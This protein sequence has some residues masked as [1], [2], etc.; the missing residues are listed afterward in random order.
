MYKSANKSS[1]ELTFRE[2]STISKRKI[3]FHFSVTLTV[4]GPFEQNIKKPASDSGTG[5]AIR[6]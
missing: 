4:F 3:A 5:Q 2:Q 6:S 1:V